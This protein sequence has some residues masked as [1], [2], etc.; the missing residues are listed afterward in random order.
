MCIRD[1]CWKDELEFDLQQD[2]AVKRLKPLDLIQEN[3]DG[4]N[5]EDALDEMMARLELQGGTLRGALDTL[6]QF[7][8]IKAESKPDAA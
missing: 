6:F 1:R 4:I 5:A 7:F 2:L 8:D 3:L